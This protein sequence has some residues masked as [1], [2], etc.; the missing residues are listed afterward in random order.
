MVP[1][2]ATKQDKTRVENESEVEDNIRQDRRSL[3]Q[4]FSG[5]GIPCSREVEHIGSANHLRTSP[6]I[7]A[8]PP[9]LQDPGCA[10]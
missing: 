7:L 5:L 8:G 10:Q 3:F 9:T 6:M 1:H 2:L 4:Y